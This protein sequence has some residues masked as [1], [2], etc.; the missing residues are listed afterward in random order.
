MGGKRIL[1]G[2]D[3]AAVALKDKLVG[4]LRA[5]GWEV[6]D[7]GVGEDCDKTVYP[8]IAARVCRAVQRAGP[9]QKALL[10]CGTGIG[11]SI[12]ANKFKGIYA[13]PIHDPFSAERAALSNDINVATLGARVVGEK[14]AEKLLL[15]WLSHE[16]K[17]GPSD[18]KILSFKKIE[19]ENFK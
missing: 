10:L 14:L 8:E 5:Q 3:N 17:S 16:Y 13:T 11:M 2:C 18:E 19:S 15:E 6:E 12:T 7:F 9:G 4:V 1:V